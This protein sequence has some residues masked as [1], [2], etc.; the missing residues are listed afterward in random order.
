MAKTLDEIRTELLE[1]MRGLYP[2]LD[3]S[4]GTILYDLILTAPSI[5]F[6][7]LFTTAENISKAQS[8][9]T[10]DLSSLESLGENLGLKR[11]GSKPSLCTITFYTN[12]AF[13]TD[14]TISKGT[15]VSTLSVDTLQSIQFSTTATVTMY[16]SLINTYFNP[17]TNRYEISVT[18]KSIQSGIQSNVGSNTV[19]QL[20]SP[21]AGI[22]GCTNTAASSGGTDV[23][24]RTTFINRILSKYTGTALGTVNGLITEISADDTVSDVKIV[25]SKDTGRLE[26]GAVDVYI[27][28]KDVTLYQDIFTTY[29]STL[30]NFVFT[31]QPVVTSFTPIVISSEIGIL[32]SSLYSITKDTSIYKGSVL[33]QDTL[34]WVSPMSTATY[35]SI[36][37][38]YQ[39]NS[40][41][42]RIQ[43]NF[44]SDSKNLL[45]TSLVIKEATEI[46]IDI[47]VSIKVLT[48]YNYASVLS[49]VQSAI[50]TFLNN[51]AIG[52]EVQQSDIAYQILAVAGVDDLLLPFTKLQ[53]SD[54]SITRN[55]SNN[56]TIPAHSYAS[57]G[58][59]TVNI[60]N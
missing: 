59:I 51:Y 48:G 37:V 1:F 19:I 7:T 13:T 43:N 16:A 56:L 26:F 47:T 41:I 35:G 42:E 20:N 5:Q 39:Y 12:K 49:K 9:L 53:S 17:T 60:T 58:T 29:N 44:N 4:E 10:A 46:L 31:K 27:K 21:I 8:I 32:S 34:T 52:E 54:G 24:G 3:F 55:A 2:N 15:I 6:E 45:N 14:I 38:D 11:K 22:D 36:Y 18:A 28:G 25:S 40:V 33:G 30:P 50:S 23:E 57:P